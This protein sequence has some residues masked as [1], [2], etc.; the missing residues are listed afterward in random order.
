LS[1]HHGARSRFAGA[2][3]LLVPDVAWLEAVEDRIDLEE[4][5]AALDEAKKKGM[6]Q[7]GAKSPSDVPCRAYF[8]SRP[9]GDYRVIYQIR[10]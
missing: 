4:T 1:P 10:D 6:A 2:G 8:L 9:A 7:E 5:H 3:E